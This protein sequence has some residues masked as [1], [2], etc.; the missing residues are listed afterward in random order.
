MTGWFYS[1]ERGVQHHA[2]DGRE[3][4]ARLTARELELGR[5]AGEL[6]DGAPL[7]ARYP[8]GQGVFVAWL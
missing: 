8:Y 3:G 1:D 2:D 6:I 5:R 4:W 7:S